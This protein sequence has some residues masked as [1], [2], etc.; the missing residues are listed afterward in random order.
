MRVARWTARKMNGCYLLEYNPLNSISLPK[1]LPVCSR[2]VIG[3]ES[4]SAALLLLLGLAQ[5]LCQCLID[6][7]ELCIGVGFQFLNAFQQFL[8]PCDHLTL[9][10]SDA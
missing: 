9:R 5:K 2:F 3:N 7:V 4:D 8:I 1:P 6:V 10:P